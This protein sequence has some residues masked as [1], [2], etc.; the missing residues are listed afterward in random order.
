MSKMLN[1]I[2][3]N[4]NMVTYLLIMFFGFA[5]MIIMFLSRGTYSVDENVDSLI[6]D[7]S[8]KVAKG[9]EIACSI[10]LN[11]V[12]LNTTGISVKYN[13]SDGI[14]FVE[15]TS[16]NWEVNTSDKDG[17]VLLNL[18]GV[19]GS[20]VVGNVKFTVPMETQSNEIYRIELVD[21]TISD[22]SDGKVTFENV[23]DEVRILSDNNTL[24]GISLSTGTLNEVFD[25]DKN[26]YTA[27]VDSDKVTITVDKTDENSVVSGDIGELS[28]HYGTNNFSIVVTSESGIQNIYTV[29][30]FREYSLTTDVYVY[31]KENNYIYTGIDIDNTV[32]LN[33]IDIPSDLSKY[34]ENGKLIISYNYIEEEYEEKLLEINVLSIDFGKYA[35]TDEIVSVDDGLTVLDFDSEFSVTDGLSYKIYNDSEEITDGNLLDGMVIKINYGDIVIDQYSINVVE[36]KLSFDSSLDI[37]DENNYIKYLNLGMTVGE[38]INKLNVVGTNVRIVIYTSST[39]N[40]SKLDNDILATGDIL[41]VYL[42]DVKKDE[43]T[44]SVL[45]DANGDSDINSIDL[46]QI[47]KHIAGWINPNTNDIYEKT[48]VYYYGI[49]MNRDGIINSIDLVRMRKKIVGLE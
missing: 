48:G 43:Y 29:S 14:E 35:V 13:V 38:L 6:I 23:Y 20:V 26:D 24:D 31:S 11:S 47:R 40:L 30:I 22:G 7:C 5:F 17:F 36:Y 1:L 34:I 45:G 46:V 19:S 33:K 49:D 9:G 21:A 42:N 3:D 32:I 37:D 10:N 16:D 15:L 44:L 25:K 28:L 27:L 8:E 41:V 18:D 2:K 12:S 39:Y 4:K